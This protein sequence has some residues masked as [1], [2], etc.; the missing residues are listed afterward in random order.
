M[1]SQTLPDW[2]QHVTGLE[3]ARSSH[4]MTTVFIISAPSGS[5][6]STLVAR[7]LARGLGLRFSVSYTTRKPRGNERPGESYNYISRAEFE[8]RIQRGEFLEHA[9]VFGNY[10][11]T[12]REVLEQAL[13]EGKDL[14]LDID[15]Q[16]ARQLKE[17]IPE[18]V[19]IFILAPSRDILEQRLRTRSEDSEEVIQRRLRDAAEEIRNY[20]QYDYE[21]VNH[22]VEESVNT[23]AAIIR[24][25]RVRRIRMEEQIRPI[26]KSF[27]ERN[28]SLFE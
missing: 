13:R 2:M 16:G 18:A 1:N 23:L 19:S 17:S 9:V 8:A 15:V 3:A 24:A 10:Y 27:E 21:L 22:Q 7:L 4:S 14:I 20:N 25:E 6:K 11:G 12:H 28:S 5:G 26:L